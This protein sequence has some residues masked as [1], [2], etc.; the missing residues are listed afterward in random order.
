[1]GGCLDFS[2]FKRKR[3]NEHMNGG[4]VWEKNEGEG[5]RETQSRCFITNQDEPVSFSC[6]HT[7]FS[8]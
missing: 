6:L 2:F 7:P 5:E 8:N 3:E 4:V 1:M